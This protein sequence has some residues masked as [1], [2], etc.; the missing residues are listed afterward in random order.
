MDELV[1][2]FETIPYVYEYETTMPNPW[3][4]VDTI[5]QE[6]SDITL[7]PYLDKKLH[8]RSIRKVDLSYIDNVA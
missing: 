3:K 1:V 4:I 6:Y 7:L 5:L 2:V 8:N